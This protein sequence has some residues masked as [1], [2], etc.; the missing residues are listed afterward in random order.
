MKKR[1]RDLPVGLSR[2]IPLIIFFIIL[3]WPMPTLAEEAHLSNIVVTSTQD[4]L[5][6]YFGVVD[7]FT[8]EMVT[9]IESGIDTTFTFFIR[10]YEKRGFR[11][12]KKIAD[13]KVKHSVKYN[14]LKK[15]YE[16]RLPEQN[17]KTMILEDFD[18][19]KELMTEV[20]ALKVTPLHT[21]KKG[22]DY[23]LRLMAELD[24]IILPFYLHRI[25]FALSLWD[26]E[27]DW[28]SIDF[29]Y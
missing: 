27:T 1:K 29:K 21:L 9:A 6:V 3:H 16:L 25:F 18:E 4:Y 5:V 11:W 19:V 28:Y 12:D 13:I 8:E 22:V 15:N 24:K 10:L 7:C 23:K 14:S 17:N 2:G 26:F 20:V